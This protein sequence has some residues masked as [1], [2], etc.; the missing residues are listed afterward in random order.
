MEDV[1]NNKP[2]LG[3]NQKGL[4]SPNQK[5]QGGARSPAE[6]RLENGKKILSKDNLIISL[7]KNYKKRKFN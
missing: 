7:K 3:L 4:F 2:K 1:T 6:P 5:R